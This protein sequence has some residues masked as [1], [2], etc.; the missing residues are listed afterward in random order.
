MCV[1]FLQFHYICIHPPLPC[2]WRWHVVMDPSNWYIYIWFSVPKF[3]FDDSLVYPS[4]FTY[5]GNASWSRRRFLTDTETIEMAENT[6]DAW[7]KLLLTPDLLCVINLMSKKNSRVPK[8][9]LSDSRPSEE[10]KH[11]DVTINCRSQLFTVLVL[12]PVSLWKE[13][14]SQNQRNWDLVVNRNHETPFN[15]LKIFISHVSLPGDR[16][17]FNFYF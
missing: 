17:I 7:Y 16:E 13:Q 6:Y 3:N 10:R 11:S 8:P 12:I 4:L 1:M 9:S 14:R 2:W 15:C 5:L